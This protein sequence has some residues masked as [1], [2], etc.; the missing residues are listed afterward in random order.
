MQYVEVGGARIPK[1]GRLDV[2]YVDL[3]L[4]HWPHPRV[5]VEETLDAIATLRTEGAVSHLGVSN[6]TR[7]QLGGDSRTG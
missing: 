6:F 1:L 7:S 3:L 5:P 2:A 4:I